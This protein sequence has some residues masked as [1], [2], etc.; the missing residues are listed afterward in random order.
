M[1]TKS[2]LVVL[3]ILVAASACRDQSPRERR[4]ANIS[5]MPFSPARVFAADTVMGGIEMSVS[6]IA[7]FGGRL[8]SAGETVTVTGRTVTVTPY[9]WWEEAGSTLDI[10]RVTPRSLRVRFDSVGIM[11][12]RVAG[13]DTTV[14]RTVV[15]RH[16]LQQDSWTH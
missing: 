3:I 10:L 13:A 1:Q 14:E 5:D 7:Y 8:E 6:F 11:T 2:R 4:Q 16:R 12:L 15:V 9:Y